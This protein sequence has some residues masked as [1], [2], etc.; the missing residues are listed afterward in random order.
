MDAV[1]I[2]YKGDEILTLILPKNHI[3]MELGRLEVPKNQEIFNNAYF[4]NYK[5]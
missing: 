1:G 3:G 4:L 5:F 2:F